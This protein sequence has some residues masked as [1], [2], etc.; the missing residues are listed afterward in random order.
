MTMLVRPVRRD[1]DMRLFCL[2]Y[3]GGS[4]QVFR[5][6]TGVAPADVEVVPLELRGRGVRFQEP[7]ETRLA[8][9]VAE[10]VDTIAAVADRPFALFGHSMGALAAFEIA[11]DLGDH[12]HLRHL[13][14]SACRPPRVPVFPRQL[15][16][17]PDAELIEALRS[18][19]ASSVGLQDAELMAAMLPVV[20]ADLTACEQHQPSGEEGPLRCG[21]TAIG[22]DADLL[23]PTEFLDGWRV[24]TTGAFR[25]EVFPGGHFFLH[26]CLPRLMATMVADLREAVR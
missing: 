25:L 6:W 5:P 8:S 4:A 15:H 18:F 9:I 14:A 12:P 20:R 3:A 7:P 2:P 23:V 22:G 21:V 11:R 17:L 13:F 1:A 10:A 16:R 19:D 24:C 26:T